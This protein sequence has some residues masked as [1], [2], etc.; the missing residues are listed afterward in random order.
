MQELIEAGYVYI[1]VRT[2]PGESQADGG[3]VPT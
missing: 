1:A 2:T 3:A